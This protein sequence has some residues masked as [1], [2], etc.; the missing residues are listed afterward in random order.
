MSHL[1]LKRVSAPAIL[2]L[3][4]IVVALALAGC[5]RRGSLEA[6]EG[7][8][9]STGAASQASPARLTPGLARNTGQQDLS[10]RDPLTPQPRGAQVDDDEA[11]IPAPNRPFILDSLL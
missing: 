6:P 2:P 11:P 8:P 5:G 4:L 10:S 3:A 7:A 1:A 9:N